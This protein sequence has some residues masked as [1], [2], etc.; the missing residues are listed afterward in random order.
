MDE[1]E[2]RKQIETK[3]NNALK[4]VLVVFDNQSPPAKLPTEW[5]RLTIQAASTSQ[6]TFGGS[7]RIS[8]ETGVITIQVFTPLGKGTAR[9]YELAGKVR[10]V[11]EYQL[12]R[13]DTWSGY[14][15]AVNIAVVGQEDENERYQI[16]VTTSYQWDRSK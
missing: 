5:A 15:R 6:A 13:G 12:V 2:F 3:V 14:T 1:L 10:D 16:N 4:P 9:A 8:R 11:L 7:N